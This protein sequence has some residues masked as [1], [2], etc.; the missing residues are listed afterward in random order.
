[1]KK[2]NKS[3]KQRKKHI[4]KFEQELEA[5]RHEQLKLIREEEQKKQEEMSQKKKMRA[6]NFDIQMDLRK[7]QRQ[8]LQQ[9]QVDQYELYMKTKPLY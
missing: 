8:E 1:M 9:K 7:K 6:Q 4:E 5:Q 3:K 2:L